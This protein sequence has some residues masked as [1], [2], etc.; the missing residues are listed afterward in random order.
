MHDTGT[1]WVGYE[2][3]RSLQIKMDFIKQ[4]GY[5]G[6]MIWA[7]DMDDFHGLCGSKNALIEILH[8]NMR[9]YVVPDRQ[10]MTTPTVC[11]QFFI[12]SSI[13]GWFH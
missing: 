8:T 5:G 7:I 11:G 2:N 12:F 4:K 6:A 1:Q 9:N 10:V 3:E 13:F